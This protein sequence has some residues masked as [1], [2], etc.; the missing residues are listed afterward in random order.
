MS[1]AGI[2]LCNLARLK[3]GSTGFDPFNEGSDSIFLVRQQNDIYGYMDICPHYGD[4]RL[5]WKKDI[6]LHK[7]Q[8]YIVCAAHGALFEIKSGTCMRGPCLG[9]KLQL[10]NIEI[11]DGEEVW[12]LPDV[13]EEN[14]T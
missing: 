9:D 10:L 2:K 6:Y 1:K 11:R 14:N 7:S 13:N 3:Q 4:T 12:W 5:P 8:K